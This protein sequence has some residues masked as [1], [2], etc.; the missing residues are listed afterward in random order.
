[1]TIISAGTAEG[2]QELL[3]RSELTAKELLREVQKYVTL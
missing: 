2:G 1:M 3:S